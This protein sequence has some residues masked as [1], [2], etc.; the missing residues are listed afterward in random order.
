MTVVPANTAKDVAVPNPTGGSTDAANA[1]GAP[2]TSAAAAI[3]PTVNTALNLRRR[4]WP[5][6]CHCERTTD[7]SA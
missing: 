1:A 3:V 5:P 6:D 2:A 4:L 7:R